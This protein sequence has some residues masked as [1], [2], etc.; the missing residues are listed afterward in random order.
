LLT[1]VIGRDGNTRTAIEE[2]GLEYGGVARGFETSFNLRK[3]DLD[4][5][6]MNT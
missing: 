1:F 5:S 3:A 6:K 4:F 2:G